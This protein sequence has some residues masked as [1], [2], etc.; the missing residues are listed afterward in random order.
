MQLI[1]IIGSTSVWILIWPTLYW[2]RSAPVTQTSRNTEPGFTSNKLIWKIIKNLCRICD[3][4]FYFFW[5]FPEVSRPSLPPV[6]VCFP[7]FLPSISSATIPSSS[8]G[9]N[10]SQLLKPPSTLHLAGS[11]SR[12]VSSRHF[13]RGCRR[14]C[15]HPKSSADAQELV[16]LRR[17]WQTAPALWSE[18]KAIS[19][20]HRGVPTLWIFFLFRDRQTEGGSQEKTEPLAGVS[21]FE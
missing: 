14:R 20:S 18:N 13:H 4:M 1:S 15:R 19:S 8:V 9:D 16:W 6:S 21:L 5:C 12:P 11:L 2:K 7:A 3:R 17:R 10:V